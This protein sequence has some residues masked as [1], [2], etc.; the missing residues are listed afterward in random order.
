MI[1]GA[2]LSSAVLASEYAGFG[3]G[4]FTGLCKGTV[5]TSKLAINFKI[6]QGT[7][8]ITQYASTLEGFSAVDGVF[9]NSSASPDFSPAVF[10]NGAATDNEGTGRARSFR[11]LYSQFC[12]VRCAGPLEVRA[13][14][15]FNGNLVGTLFNG[16]YATGQGIKCNF[17]LPR[18]FCCCV[19]SNPAGVACSCTD[20]CII[21]AGC[22]LCPK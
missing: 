20:S 14:V 18:V 13:T 19:A 11:V 6:S 5:L 1:V 3:P 9:T 17:D 2:L 8:V 4:R 16:R 10:Y 7:A 21:P 15:G 12:S 22:P